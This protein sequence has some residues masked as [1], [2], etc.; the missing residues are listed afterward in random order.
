MADPL[1][2]KVCT[3]DG[4][5]YSF[6]FPGRAFRI[7]QKRYGGT[8][9]M[10]LLTQWDVDTVC[11][12]AAAGAQEKHP[13]VTDM[14]FEAAIDADPDSYEALQEAVRDAVIEGYSRIAPKSGPKAAA[15]TAPHS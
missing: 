13:G 9:V 3:I 11:E 15:L 7:A 12:L 2:G 6:L 4:T 1:K 14:T 8:P 5:A 10:Q